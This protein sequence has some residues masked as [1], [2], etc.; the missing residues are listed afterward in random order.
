MKKATQGV[1]CIFLNLFT[2]QY[3]LRGATG[4]ISWYSLGYF[5]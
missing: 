1:M 4:A 3:G 5:M 2:E